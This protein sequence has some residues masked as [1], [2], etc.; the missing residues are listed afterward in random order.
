MQKNYKH[1]ETRAI[2]CWTKDQELLFLI[3]INVSAHQMEFTDVFLK[4]IIICIVTLNYW[5]LVPWGKIHMGKSK[6][7]E[8]TTET[9]FCNCSINRCSVKLEKIHSKV[10][11]QGSHLNIATGLQPATLLRRRT[12]H[13]CFSFRFS[14][15]EKF[16][17]TF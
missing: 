5:S 1:Y 2:F 4:L 10:T 3:K 16:L 13:R 11:V 12:W 15:A 6:S 9:A 17:L 8:K 7:W 14:V